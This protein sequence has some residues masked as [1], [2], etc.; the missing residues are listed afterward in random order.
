V[1]ENTD[2]LL[3]RIDSPADLRALPESALVPLAAELRDF[4]LTTVADNGG[5]LSAGLGTVELTVALHYLFDTPHDLLVWD[6]G[7]QCY[8]H[9]ILTGRRD[10]LATIRKRGGPSVPGTRA[11]RS[12]RRSA[13]RSRARRP[14]SSA[15]RWRS[16]ATVA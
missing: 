12:A 13:W 8:P 1:T 7:H 2:R 4:M 6:V 10:R 3:H 14:A 5:H 9:K 11:P 15:T 16:S